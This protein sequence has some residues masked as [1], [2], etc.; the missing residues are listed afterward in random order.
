MRIFSDNTL[1]IAVD[2]QEK[3]VPS[4]HNNTDILK[5]SAKFIEG[6][7]ILGVPVI[8]TEQYKK[9]LGDT[10]SEVK[11]VLKEYKPYEKITFSAYA[12]MDIKDAIDSFDV[13]NILV[14]GTECHICVLQT[15]IDLVDGDYNVFL[16]EDCSGSRYEND[17]QYGIKRAE[18][19]GA[20]S[21]TSEAILFEL[22]GI[23]KTEKFKKILKIVK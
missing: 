16:V 7:N 17:K 22:T 14:F 18:F 5:N 6:L 12:D 4:I 21:V 9:G 8:V 11:N 23:A 10:C 20:C 3:L 1:A 13:K 19:E 15:I 2:L